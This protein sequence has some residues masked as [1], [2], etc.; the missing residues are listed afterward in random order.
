MIQI[1]IE[2]RYPSALQALG[3]FECVVF[4]EIFEHMRVNLL[5]TISLLRNLLAEN[6]I[7]YLTT[8]NGLGLYA[9]MEL[10]RGRT[11]SDPVGEWSKLA[12]FGHMGHVRE[13]SRGEVASILR[14]CGFVVEQQF[15]RRS[16]RRGT[17]RAKVA[18]VAKAVVT[19]GFPRLGD[20]LVF[21]LRKAR[22]SSAGKT[23]PTALEPNSDQSAA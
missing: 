20:E 13:Y 8:P 22:Q 4:C 17:L 1:D 2:N 6:G 21:V 12:E 14:H 18:N 9:L 15:F 23:A 5:G 11:G 16:R 7:L 19:T 10:L 3:Q